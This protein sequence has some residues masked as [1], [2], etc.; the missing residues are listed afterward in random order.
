MLSDF[1]RA[2]AWR[3]DSAIS[4]VVTRT[5]RSPRAIRNRSKAPETCRQSSRAHTRSLPSSRAQMTS[6]AKPVAPTCTVR[7]LTN[8]PVVAE[9]AAI[10]CERLWLSAPSTIIDL[11][12]L[13]LD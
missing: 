13:H 6:A 7:S 4:L 2:R 12:H 3:R 8:S 9:T 11:V 10:V 1:P 5:T